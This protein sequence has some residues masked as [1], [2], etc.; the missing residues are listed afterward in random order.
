MFRA[1]FRHTRKFNGDY[2]R[3]NT[4]RDRT[5]RHRGN[6]DHSSEGLGI[7]KVLLLAIAAACIAPRSFGEI[8]YVD[9]N[10]AS[11]TPPYTNWAMAAVTIQDAINISTNGDV[12]LV[13]N[14]A[15]ATGGATITNF[16][17]M[18]NRVVITNFIRVTSVNGPLVTS[19]VG[20]YDPNTGGA[21]SNA[22]RCALVTGG[23]MLDGFTLTNG[24]TATSPGNV[25]AIYGGGLRL[26]GPSTASNLIIRNCRAA[27]EGGGV[28]LDNPGP[29][30]LTH[31]VIMDNSANG[32]GGAVTFNG[33]S[34]VRNCLLIR[35]TAL[36]SGGGANMA[37]VNGRIEA[38]TIAGNVAPQ[39]GGIRASSVTGA[40]VVNTIIS[41]NSTNLGQYDGPTN[42]VTFSCSP[43]AIDGTGNITNDPRFVDAVDYRIRAKSP[44]VDAGT[45]LAWM[46]AV[47]AKDLDGEPRLRNGIADIGA[48]EAWRFEA[49][50]LSTS[51]GGL[52]MIWDVVSN[53]TFELQGN[54]NLPGHVWTN[55]GVSVTTGAAYVTTTLSSVSAPF[56]FFRLERQ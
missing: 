4:T 46:L 31:S 9:L 23:G 17:A 32:P 40:K 42:V 24:A 25:S 26:F 1:Y 27:S 53:G 56:E 55:V 10:S 37:I 50:S 13:T 33:N 5:G 21:G 18:T 41:G 2:E 16:P 52:V 7:G 36:G 39:G 44:C 11:P 12:V 51:G 34:T 35:N 54:V 29:A 48:D 47:G 6:S 14:G 49:L 3:M 8:R 30:V 15:Y 19:I 45:N 28:L 20:Q 22:V 43:Q 38:C